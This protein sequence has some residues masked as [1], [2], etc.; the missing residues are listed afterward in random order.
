M[1][2]FVLVLISEFC[3]GVCVGFLVICCWFLCSFLFLSLF[4]SVIMV[5][6]RLCWWPWPD[7][8]LTWTRQRWEIF[9]DNYHFFVL[10]SFIWYDDLRLRSTVH[11]WLLIISTYSQFLSKRFG[12][13]YKR[14]PS[15]R[16]P[17]RKT[18]LTGYL[19]QPFNKD[20]LEKFM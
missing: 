19:I 14:K 10:F 16:F 4:L 7:L 15:L 11:L 3:S 12:L 13:F 6:V 2:V 9:Y 5:L 20:W 17:L 8:Q 1:L 18:I